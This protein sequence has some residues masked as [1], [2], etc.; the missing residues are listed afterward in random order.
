M[1]ELL[2]L[3]RRMSSCFSG[4]Y[5]PIARLSCKNHEFFQTSVIKKARS[6]Q[7]ILYLGINF[8]DISVVVVTFIL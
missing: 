4:N 7:C 1:K 8:I 6:I 2:L 3:Q 5:C